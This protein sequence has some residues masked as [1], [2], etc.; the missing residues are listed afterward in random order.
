MELRAVNIIAGHYGVGKTTLSLNLALQAAA[1]GAHPTVADL[2]VVNPYFRATEYRT[3]LE[4]RGVLV[5]APK[6]SEAGTN[7]DAPALNGAIVPAIESASI[8]SPLFIDAGG[9]EVGATA[10]GRFSRKIEERP[11]GFLYV[12]NASRIG[13]ADAGEAVRVLREIEH[14]AHLRATGIVS[15]AHLMDHTDLDVIE[16][17]ADLAQRTAEVTGLPLLGITVPEAFVDDDAARDPARVSERAR[18]EALA[19]V[20]PLIPIVAHVRTPWQEDVR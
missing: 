6:F 2:D 17:G 7:L 20:A 5:V 11:H 18:L 8:S 16:Q 3:L 12:V 13:M 15:N 19:D 4:E 10:L 14:A 9:D 1:A